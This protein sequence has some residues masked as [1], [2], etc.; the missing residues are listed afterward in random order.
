MKHKTL[1]LKY[2]RY[3][4]KYKVLREEVIDLDTDEVI[5]SVRM[6]DAVVHGA[7]H[8]MGTIGIGLVY[9]KEGYT[10]IDITYETV[11]SVLRADAEGT[12]YK[13]LPKN[14]EKSEFG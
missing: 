7:V 4:Y 11:K 13:D 3:K 9:A 5:Y 1:R 8:F 14:T 10:D 12:P 6:A 2:V